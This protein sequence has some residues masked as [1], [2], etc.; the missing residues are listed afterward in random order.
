MA[1]KKSGTTTVV[2]LQKTRRTKLCRLQVHD[3]LFTNCQWAKP[4]WTMATVTDSNRSNY[5][6]VHPSIDIIPILGVCISSARVLN[7]RFD[8]CR[9]DWEL[10][11]EK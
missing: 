7:D 2:R 10:K 5:Y 9:P 1:S 6:I 4:H 11:D 3:E 8:R